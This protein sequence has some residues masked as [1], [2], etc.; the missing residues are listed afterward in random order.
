METT[1]IAYEVGGATMIGRLARPDGQDRRPAV[2]IA[3]EGNGLDDFQKRRPERFAD[4]GYV[5]FALDYHG[6]GQ[7]LEGRAEI[8]ARLTELIDDPDRTRALG[9]AGLDVLVAQP[10]VDPA[11]VAAVGYCFGGTLV[12]EL[13]RTGADLRA[14]VGFHPGL[15]TQ[16]PEDSANIVGKVLVCVGADD[17]IIPV[18]QRLAFEEEMR[19]AAID[20]QMN[21]YGGARHSFTNPR[22]EQAGT[23]AL[24]YHDPSDRRSWRA[25]VDLFDEVF[26]TPSED[27]LTKGDTAR[28]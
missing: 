16:R 2:L 24:A 28:P 23:P 4:L 12:L 3:H 1:D 17:P 5:A 10:G 27:A 9:R 18:E 26:A 19:T 6:G 20:W 25:M 22:A 8:N 21:L 11:K 13:A 14:I 7:P 15:V